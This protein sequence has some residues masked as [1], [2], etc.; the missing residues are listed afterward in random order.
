MCWCTPNKRQPWCDGC[1]TVRPD[2]APKETYKPIA[3]HNGK[4]SAEQ[5]GA[6]LAYAWRHDPKRLLFTAARYSFVAKMLEGKRRV[7]EVGCGDAFF[8][9]IVQQHVGDIVAIDKDKMFVDD[10]N[11]RMS[12]SWPFV[13][14]KHDMNVPFQ[15]VVF[16]AIYALDVLEHIKP[17]DEDRFIRN[18]LISLQTHGM[19]V[20][21]M[22]SLESQHLGSLLSRANHVN[23]KSLPDFKATMEKYFH[24]VLPFSMNDATLH[25]GNHAM[26]HYLFC[27]CAGKK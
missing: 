13:C 5:L 2:L 18:C 25:T 12:D 10:V 17:A 3:E 14:L 11:I 27:V 20:F 21:G 7:L 6:S 19:L 24:Y 8:T 9:R 15:S 26:S 22:P 23:C 4:Q 1:I 16:D